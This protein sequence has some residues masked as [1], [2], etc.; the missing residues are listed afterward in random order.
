MDKIGDKSLNEE[1]EIINLL[2]KSKEA[3]SNQ[4]DWEMKK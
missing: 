3:N 4:D 1:L 2:Q